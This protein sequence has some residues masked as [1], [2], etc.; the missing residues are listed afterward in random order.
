MGQSSSTQLA[1]MLIMKLEEETV[2]AGSEIRELYRFYREKCA[3]SKNGL[4]MTKGIFEDIFMRTYP[5]TDSG[6]FTDHVYRVM[7]SLDADDFTF[8]DFLCSLETILKGNSEEKVHWVFKLLDINSDGRITA[9]ERKAVAQSLV[10]LQPHLVTELSFLEENSIDSDLLEKI[11]DAKDEDIDL[12]TFKKTATENTFCRNFIEAAIKAA[13]KPYWDQQ[14]NTGSFGRRRSSTIANKA[15]H[16][17]SGSGRSSL[18]TVAEQGESR[19]R[20]R[21]MTVS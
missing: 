12:L 5:R 21:S 9:I 17:G 14:E 7:N 8:H 4:K 6:P 18:D 19:R 10:E 1:P 2:F 11:F 3:P 16:S 15:V 13:G 20:S